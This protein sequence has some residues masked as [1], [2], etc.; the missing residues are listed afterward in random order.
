VLRLLLSFSIDYC[1]K[2]F[3]LPT[4]VEFLEVALCFTVKIAVLCVLYMTFWLIC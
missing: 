1:S 4:N 3:I 2:S